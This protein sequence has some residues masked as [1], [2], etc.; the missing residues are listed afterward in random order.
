MQSPIACLGLA[1]LA[2]LSSACSVPPEP[3]SPRIETAVQLVAALRGAGAE[4][5]ETAILPLRS[6]LSGGQVVFVGPAEVEIYQFETEAARQR[7]QSH[8]LAQNWPGDAPN[9]WGRGR[10]VVVY[11]GVDGPTIALLSAFLGDVLDLPGELAVEPYPP[12]VAAAIGWLA[13]SLSVDPGVVRVLAYSS[14]EWPDACLG[15][16]GPD[17]VCAEVV[18]PGWRI[19]LQA[20]G[21]EPSLRTDELGTVSRAEP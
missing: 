10:V 16:P 15:L 17:E 8:L 20:D 14:A 7:A 6:G 5:E 2:T 13:E 3:D 19:V 9:V 11:P 12:A 21:A 1:I 4:V 18:T